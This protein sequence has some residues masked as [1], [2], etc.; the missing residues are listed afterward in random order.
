MS[1]EEE[2]LLPRDALLTAGVHI[3]TKIKEKDM[4]PYVFRVRSDGLAILDIEKADERIRIAAKFLSRFEPSSAVAVSAREYGWE[5]VNKFCKLVGAVPIVG[6]FVPG[7][8]S[9][10]TLPSH[11]EPR[12]VLVS[13]PSVDSQAV[14]EASL[15]GVA[16]VALCSTNNRVMNI[17][18]VIPANNK[19]RRSL[20][21]I[22]W[23]LAREV[24]RERGA[25]GKDEDLPL[26]ID[27]FEVKI[28]EEAEGESGK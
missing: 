26:S 20:A 1:R 3:G 24:L 8:F 5:P 10:P 7:T 14:T 21:T 18:L 25:L 4:E 15:M 12:V 19:G 22:F 11:V 27:D 17:D 9:N 16:V 6:R 13:D 28:E 2:L 23:L